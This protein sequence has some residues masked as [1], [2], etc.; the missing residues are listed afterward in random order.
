LDPRLG[1]SAPELASATVLAPT[2]MLADALAT[3]VMVSGVKAGLQLLQHFPGC[4]AYLVDKH[5]QTF[6]S[7][8][9]EKYLV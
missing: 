9:M 4:E 6:S 2:A 3:A 7:P 1:I 5:L 8:G